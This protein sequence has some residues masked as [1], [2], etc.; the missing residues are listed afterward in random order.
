MVADAGLPRSVATING[1][2]VKVGML[3]T[4]MDLE[5]QGALDV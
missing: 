5:I 3:R 1:C 2:S 4:P